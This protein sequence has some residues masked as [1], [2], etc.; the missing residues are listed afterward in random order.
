MATVFR[1]PEFAVARLSPL[2]ADTPALRPPDNLE[3]PAHLRA[4]LAAIVEDPLVREAIAVSSLSLDGLLDKAAEGAP[5]KTRQLRGAAASALR[6]VTRM[7]HRATPFGLMA[8]VA[9]ATFGDHTTVRI[10]SRHYKHVRPDLAWLVAVVRVLNRDPAVRSD[11]CVVVNDLCCAQGDRLVVPRLLGEDGQGQEHGCETTVVRTD[12]VRAA[13]DF[14]RT[15]VAFRGLVDKVAT[16][17]P[18]EDKSTVEK[19]LGALVEQ[20]ILLTELFPPVTTADPLGHVLST[21]AASG[22]TPVRERLAKVASALDDYAA[23]PVGTGH[24][25]LRTAA[26]MMRG[27]HPADRPLHVDLGMDADIVLPNEVAVEL[28]DAASMAWRLSPPPS[29]ALAAYHAEFLERYGLRGLVPIRELL[30]PN[31][32]LGPPAGYLAPPAHHRPAGGEKPDAA[33]ETLLSGLA[34]QAAARGETEVVVDTEL[35]DRL[36]RPG[37]E[38]EPGA[39]IEPVA[40]LFAA[41]SDHLAAGDFRLLLSTTSFTRPGAMFGRFLHLL[42]KL[43]QPFARCVD[44]LAASWSPATTAQ[45][46]ASTLDAR[47]ANVAQVPRLTPNTL[48]LGAFADS[49]DPQML[50]LDDLAVGAYRNRLCVVSLRTGEEIVPQLFHANEVRTS[51]PNPVRLLFQIGAFHTPKWSLWN[52]GTAAERLPF[53]PRIR[54]GRTVLASARWLPDERLTAATLPWGQW[55]SL[56]D[57]W[58]EE[59]KVPPH[60]EAAWTDQ[61]LPLD[62]SSA[63]DLRLLRDELRRHPD[64]VLREQ[65]LGGE[66]G[67]GW[68]GGHS[69]ELAVALRPTRPRR[70]HPAT[71]AALPPSTAADPAKSRQAHHPGGDWLYLKVYVTAD[72]HDEILTHALPE[73]LHQAA[74]VTDRW[75]YVRY[76]DDEPHLRIRFHGTP[77]ELNS[78]LL[79]AVRHWADLLAESGAIR[80]LVIATYRPELARYGGPDVMT[81]AEQAFSADSRAAID[82]LRLRRQG[83]WTCPWS[84]SWPRTASTSRHGLSGTGGGNGYSGPTPKTG[85]TMPSSAADGRRSNSSARWRHLAQN[86][87]PCRARSD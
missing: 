28:A 34:Q 58:R 45:L 16:V 64:T 29:H 49:G 53:L 47:S 19:Q 48:V 68:S 73:L 3:N 38:D 37:A 75:F 41:S 35:A 44:E 5:M 70:P 78:R 23:A 57:R 43:R 85:T 14:A 77:A 20:D 59:W 10:G 25:P 42:P 56:F 81:A 27:I 86:P 24:L 21:L 13:L 71:R 61:L 12:V 33:R 9:H 22:E 74:P 39:Y 65:P 40:R 30:D 51:V 8:G 52:W 31:T 6:Y 46:V 26:G 82:Q 66:Y 32:G 54:H 11:L 60:V 67:T 2:G 7:R 62:L 36:A 18:D 72:R 55:R 63:T 83:Y 1:E 15:P 69:C 50:R 84:S 17:C 76:Q 79:P 80:D 87:W 4:F